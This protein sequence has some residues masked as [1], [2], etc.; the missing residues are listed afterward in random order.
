MCVSICVGAPG[1]PEHKLGD[2]CAGCFIEPG[3]GG[4]PKNMGMNGFGEIQ[5]ICYFAK[6]LLNSAVAEAFVLFR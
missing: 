3:G 5:F 6:P 1:M 4:V 2:G